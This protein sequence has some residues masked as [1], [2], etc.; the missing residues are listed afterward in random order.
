MAILKKILSWFLQLFGKDV[1]DKVVD[2]VEKKTG[3]D[4]PEDTIVEF[5]NKILPKILDNPD[6]KLWDT[7]VDILEKMDKG[8]VIV[9]GKSQ[10]GKTLLLTI[11]AIYTLITKPN[12]T[13]YVRSNSQQSG[14]NLFEKLVGVIE[15]IKDEFGITDVKW[16]NTS[17]VLSNGSKLTLS[18]SSD[19]TDIKPD[20]DLLIGDEISLWE[21]KALE[22]LIRKFPKQG[23]KIRLVTSDWDDKL[24]KL[25]DFLPEG[26]ELVKILFSKNKK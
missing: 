23:D 1:V 20:F 19:L 13:V 10:T 22:L 5:A 21:T 25:I 6:A 7:Q 8:G 2:V 9:E 15:N 18:T 4:I 11:H 26:I 12:T 3:W 24:N 17:L 16:L 14:E